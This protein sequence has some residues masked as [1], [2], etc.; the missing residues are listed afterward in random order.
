MKTGGGRSHGMSTQCGAWC[1]T[2]S[3]CWQVLDCSLAFCA[4]LPPS[5]HGLEAACSLLGELGT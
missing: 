3:L 4:V 1:L 2:L 5:C